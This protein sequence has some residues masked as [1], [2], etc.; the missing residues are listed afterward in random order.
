MPKNS[1]ECEKAITTSYNKFIKTNHVLLKNQ[2]KRVGTLR[3]KKKRR[4]NR[5]AKRIKVSPSR[6]VIA[7]TTQYLSNPSL[8]RKMNVSLNSKRFTRRG[9]LNFVH[10]NKLRFI[11]SKKQLTHHQLILNS[12]KRF[13]LLNFYYRVKQLR[14]DRIRK[15]VKLSKKFV[16][17]GLNE[18]S[19]VRRVKNLKTTLKTKKKKKNVQAFK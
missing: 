10:L 18:V 6:A 2:I 7:K 17:L 14:K 4:S 15:L 5:R 19:K 9:V 12:A 16:T 13:S 8:K 3:V 1:V 11:Y